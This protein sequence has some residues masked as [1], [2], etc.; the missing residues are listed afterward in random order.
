MGTG[1]ARQ[2]VEKA[3]RKKPLAKRRLL[4]MAV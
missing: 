4:H 2:H 1:E 3:V